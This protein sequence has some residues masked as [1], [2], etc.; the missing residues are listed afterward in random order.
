MLA[1]L[2]DL[3]SR[4]RRTM[5]ACWGG[6]TL[7]GF[8][9][10]LYSCVVPTVIAVWGMSTG[11]AGTLQTPHRRHQRTKRR[12]SAPWESCPSGRAEQRSPVHRVHSAHSRTDRAGV[13]TLKVTPRSE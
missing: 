6:W 11:A 13:H 2:R 12:P 7:D 9:Q 3:T 8:D 4:E 1:W 5:L 10:Q